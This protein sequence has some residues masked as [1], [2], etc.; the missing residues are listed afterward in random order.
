MLGAG[1]SWITGPAGIRDQSP[2]AFLMP[3]EL[4]IDL[5]DALAFQV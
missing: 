4:M 2:Q 5:G 3:A 1:Q